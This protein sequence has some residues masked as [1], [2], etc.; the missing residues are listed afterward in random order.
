MI[1]VFGHTESHKRLVSCCALALVRTSM[2]TTICN[3]HPRFSGRTVECYNARI[4]PS[5]T[6]Q[7]TLFPGN[8]LFNSL[9][10]CRAP[11]II[12]KDVQL[13]KFVRR[14]AGPQPGTN[15]SAQWHD[16]LHGI[17]LWITGLVP[18]VDFFDGQRVTVHDSVLE[19]RFGHCELIRRTLGDESTCV[20]FAST[21]FFPWSPTR[22]LG[23]YI[24][25]VLQVHSFQQLL[26]CCEKCSP[27]GCSAFVFPWLCSM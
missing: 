15:W 3:K 11:T 7:T 10:R 4:A 5:N 12:Q 1:E 25:N 18:V 26:N 23:H 24:G 21:I 13:R 16:I 2:W 19:F 22:S 14:I 27:L 6:G 9:F 8:C 17:Y 20:E